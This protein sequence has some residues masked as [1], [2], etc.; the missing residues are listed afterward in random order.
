VLYKCD[1]FYHKQ[2][3][4]GL[5]YNDPAL[6]IDWRIPA[7]KAIVADKDLIHPFIEKCTTNF[8]Y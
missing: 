5:L 4:G 1:E 3:E 7:D 8:T 6:E 2:S